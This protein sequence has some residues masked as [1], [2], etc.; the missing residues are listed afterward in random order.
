MSSR[1]TKIVATLGPAVDGAEK[2]RALIQA[3]VDAV[4]LNFSHGTHEEHARRIGWVRAA[5][6]R[7]AVLQDLQGPRIRTG[8]LRGGG[9]VALRT[10]ASVT[11][12]TRRIEGTDRCVPV[13]YPRLP[14]DVHPGMTVLI[15][16]GALQ[17]EVCRVGKQTVECR[18]VV[19][20]DLGENKGLN[21]PEA[22]F[23]IDPFTE[24]DRR[25]LEFGIAQGVDFVALSFVKEARDLVRV[26]RFIRQRGADIPLIAKIERRE[27]VERIGEILD[28]A[29]GIM[30]ARG[31]LGIETSSADV[32]ILQKRLIFESNRRSRLDITATQMLESMTANPRPTRAEACDVA[33]AV[34]D[35]TDALMLSAETAAGRYPLE[36][37]RTMAQIAE[38][39]EQELAHF[40]HVSSERAAEDE[41]V[42]SATARAACLAA[43]DLG[44]R[45]IAVLTESGRSAIITSQRRPQAPILAFTPHPAT[46]RRLALAWGVSAYLCARAERL[47]DVVATLE[48]RLLES[49]AARRGELVVL[50]AGSSML[51]GATNTVRV[52]RVGEGVSTPSRRAVRQ[53]FGDIGLFYIRLL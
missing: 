34:F 45:A 43:R 17:L 11:L 39:A 12:T 21:V 15:A 52:L 25:D 16:D 41:S 32:P 30:V 35:G 7:V 50:T 20:G 27:A 47:E 5:S 10:G 38:R 26:R 6:D 37:V 36:A 18:V 19:G 1:R 23:S 51:P 8:R 42:G 14:R 4:R 13:T 2:V 48:R 53:R 24:K 22:S 49:G 9:P 46:V 44:A 33:N 40:G 29:D 3:G 31:D 28:A